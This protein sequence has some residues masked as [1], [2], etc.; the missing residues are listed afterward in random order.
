MVERNLRTVKAWLLISWSCELSSSV[1][2]ITSI[3]G[4]LTPGVFEAS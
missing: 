1:H 4:E 2:L 3:N